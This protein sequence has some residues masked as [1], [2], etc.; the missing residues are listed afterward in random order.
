M[1]LVR[2]VDIDDRLIAEL[3]ECGR[4]GHNIALDHSDDPGSNGFTFGVDRYQR[5]TE[6]S[7]DVLV[8]AGFEVRRVGAGLMASRPEFELHFA[9][10][11]G[12]DLRDPAAFD[13]ASSPARLRAAAANSAQATIPGLPLPDIRPVVHFVWSGDP[14]NGLTA[15]HLGCLVEASGGRLD[16]DPLVQVRDEHTRH[17]SDGGAS[18]RPKVTFVDQPMPELKLRPRPVERSDA[19]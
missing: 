2:N 14:A 18:E 7:L 16:W 3:V 5:S 6:L 9:V 15:A 8:G 1:H 10:A 4:Q 19:G 11:R 12:S 13:A 17:G